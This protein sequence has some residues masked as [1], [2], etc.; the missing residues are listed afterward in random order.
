M[1]VP[2]HFVSSRDGETESGNQTKHQYIQEIFVSNL[3][4]ILECQLRA[5]NYNMMAIFMVPSIKNKRA[6][7]P[8]DIFMD[9]GSSMFT[10]GMV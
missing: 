10:I 1:G 7:K 3:D 5:E 2:L 9:D 8:G 4:K 6:R